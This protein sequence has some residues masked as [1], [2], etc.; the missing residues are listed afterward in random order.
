[1]PIRNI[2]ASSARTYTRG[3]QVPPENTL[4]GG[5]NEI[6]FEGFFAVTRVSAR[7][8]AR[9][10]A[11]FGCIVAAL[12]AFSAVCRAVTVEPRSTVA[13]V[14]GT[15][16][17]QATQVRLVSWSASITYSYDQGKYSMTYIEGGQD[18]PTKVSNGTMNFD[19]HGNFWIL[20]TEAHIFDQAV[21]NATV[22]ITCPAT[23]GGQVTYNPGHAVYDAPVTQTITG[24]YSVDGSGSGSFLV[25]GESNN[26]LDFDL[27]AFNSA[28]IATVLLVRSFSTEIDQTTGVA[29]RH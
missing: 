9:C 16:Q 28:G 24:T 17:F 23:L 25:G 22:V 10:V 21:S 15:Y 7:L 20:N 6:A 1:M 5:C 29:L 19:G 12:L 8:V 13:S 3:C 11:R 18:S 4:V 14:I 27:T 26:G 2:G